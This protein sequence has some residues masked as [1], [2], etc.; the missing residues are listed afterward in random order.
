[1]AVLTAK[2]RKGLPDSDFAI[3]ERREYPIQDEDHARN[4]LVRVAQYGTPEDKRRV[5]AA[6]KARY[7][8][9]Q[10]TVKESGRDVVATDHK[11]RTGRRVGSH[12]VRVYRKRA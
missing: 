9:I 10:V 3:P 11:G 4:A 12:S 2:K 5:R 8:D 6:V 7:P 1:M